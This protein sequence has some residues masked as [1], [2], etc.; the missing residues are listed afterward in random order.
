[1]NQQ[2]L[3]SEY[4]VS[5]SDNLQQ[6]RIDFLSNEFPVAISFNGISHVV[7]MAT[8]MDLEDF[9]IGFS[10]TEGIISS[11]DDVFDIEIS[12]NDHGIDVEVEIAQEPFQ[13]LK[14]L[15]RN[16]SGKTGCGICGIESLEYFT[17]RLKLNYPKKKNFLITTKL[18]TASLDTFKSSQKGQVKT[19]SIHAA[20]L[21]DADGNL[22]SIKEDVGR[23]NALDK[24]I[25]R[26]LID[27]LDGSFIVCSSR[28]SYEMVQKVLVTDIP[29]LIA[30]SAP[31][32]MA[33]NLALQHDLSVI[34]F[35]RD[36]RF[37]VY[38]HKNR[39]IE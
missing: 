7:M 26:K 20:A 1:M 17:N 27:N 38:S 3:Y 19:G 4:K 15:K 28:A 13:K 29:I 32:S 6:N 30:I 36:K 21:F 16:L 23:H 22:Q 11:I 34:G 18:I 33:V 37:V 25:G 39:I 31:T 9:V 24:L 14:H 12:K 5:D 35:A 8:P 2:N 10:F